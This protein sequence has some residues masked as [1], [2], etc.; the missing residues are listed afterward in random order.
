MRSPGKAHPRTTPGV[1]A[2]P[3]RSDPLTLVLLF[4]KLL[5]TCF[6]GPISRRKPCNA[7]RV[8]VVQTFVL[9]TLDGDP[10]STGKCR[11]RARDVWDGACDVGG[12]ELSDTVQILK[13]RGILI[14][15]LGVL[16]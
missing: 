11:V 13:I 3:H 16:N 4:I 15:V 14:F 12:M 1:P 10:E 6:V 9:L 7:V 2:G 5:N 8:S